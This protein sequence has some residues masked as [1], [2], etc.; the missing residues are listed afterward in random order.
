MLYRCVPLTLIFNLLI[1]YIVL[2][3]I[4]VQPKQKCKRYE[5]NDEN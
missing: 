1:F 5:M 4:I 3:L 2:E